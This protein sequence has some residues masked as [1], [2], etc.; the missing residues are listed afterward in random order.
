[1]CVLSAI[2]TAALINQQFTMSE[3]SRNAAATPRD[4]DNREFSKDSKQMNIGPQKDADGDA[5]TKNAQ[6]PTGCYLCHIPHS[7]LTLPVSGKMRKC[8][9]CK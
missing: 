4:H 6:Q 2:G 9:V 3:G 1:M 7:K 8:S 5:D